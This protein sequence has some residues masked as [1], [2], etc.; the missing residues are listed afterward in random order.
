MQLGETERTR[1]RR[2]PTRSVQDRDML[3]Q[4]IDE[5]YVCHV[6][7][8]HEMHPFVIPTLGWRQGDVVYIHGSKGS[9]MV[10]V[11]KEGGDACITFTLLDG[12][13]MARSPFHHSANYRSAVILGRPNAI[14]GEA[15]KLSALRC[16]MDQ[17]AP[18][19]WEKLRATSSQ[20]INA[21]DVLQLP[22][23]EA[24]VKVRTGDPGDDA[25][26]LD[27]PVW[28]GVIP[29]MHRV[30]PAV[31]AANNLEPTPDFAAQFG[32]RWQDHAPN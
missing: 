9:R 28:A 31:P 26:D 4:I 2:A 30:G 5:S 29:M 13:V 27:H 19:R 21:T 7:F 1:I 17:I 18:G 20:E 10:K 25:D 23:V 22:I 11:L 32:N 15:E 6:G 24:S 3:Y 14:E 16:F 8:V 12:L